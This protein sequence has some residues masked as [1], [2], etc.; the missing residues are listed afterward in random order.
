[1]DLEIRVPAEEEYEMW[2]RMFRF[3]SGHHAIEQDATLTEHVDRA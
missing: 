2:I 3:A 1:M